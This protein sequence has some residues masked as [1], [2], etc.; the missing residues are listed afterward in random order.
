MDEIGEMAV[1]LQAKLLRVLESGEYMVVGD[2]KP[3]RTDVRVIAATNR[4]L[5]REIAEGNFREDLYYRL[6]GLFYPFTCIG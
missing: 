2:T 3:S 6:S 1:E 5:S 4:D